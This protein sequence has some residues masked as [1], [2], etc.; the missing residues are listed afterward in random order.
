[1]M[2]TRG[3]WVRD[4]PCALYMQCSYIPTHPLALI[5]TQTHT[6]KQVW[7][8]CSTLLWLARHADAS[9]D[10]ERSCDDLACIKFAAS[11]C[12]LQ[13]LAGGTKS[14]TP[15][16]LVHADTGVGAL[17]EVAAVVQVQLIALAGVDRLVGFVAR[18][19]FVADVGLT[20]LRT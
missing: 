1:M 17:P 9:L 12:K 20:R 7:A 8:T 14:T 13:R 19:E 5:Q 4:A 18:Y 3:I 2:V 6:G 16:G 11:R 15:R 10:P